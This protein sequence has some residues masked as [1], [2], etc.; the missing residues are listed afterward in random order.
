MYN[1]IKTKKKKRRRKK[2]QQAKR[3]RTH[4]NDIIVWFSILFLI[5]VILIAETNRNREPV[6]RPVNGSIP[7]KKQ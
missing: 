2:K 5:Y 4:D 6:S 3:Q 7:S 1:L